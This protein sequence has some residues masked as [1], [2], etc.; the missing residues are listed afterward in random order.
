VPEGASAAAFAWPKALEEALAGWLDAAGPVPD[1]DDPRVV[2]GGLYSVYSPFPS[3]TPDQRAFL[4]TLLD[5]L[6]VLVGARARLRVVPKLLSPNGQQGRSKV[7]LHGAADDT[8]RTGALFRA[9]IGHP[10]W[11]IPA[12]HLVSRGFHDV[13]PGA[14]PVATSAHAHLAAHRWF[15]AHFPNLPTTEASL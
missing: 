11:P 1:L 3:P 10:A 9:I 13:G 8:E 12:T 5:H 2:E 15:A 4:D 6:S 7:T 14:H